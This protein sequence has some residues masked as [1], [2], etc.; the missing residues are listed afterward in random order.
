MKKNHQLLLFWLNEASFLTSCQ[1]CHLTACTSR[2][3]RGR[4]L[5]GVPWPHAS[6][7]GGQGELERRRHVVNHL[8][9]EGS[10]VFAREPFCRSIFL[11]V[12]C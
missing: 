6:V 8:D 12:I 7:P 11:T 4:A 1:I 3:G 10:L 2:Q 9:F 5:A